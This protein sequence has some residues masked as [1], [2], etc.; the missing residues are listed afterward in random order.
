LP[1]P[2]TAKGTMLAPRRP[3]N[4]ENVGSHRGEI[5]IMY[6]EAGQ[7][8]TASMTRPGISNGHRGQRRIEHRRAAAGVAIE[9]QEVENDW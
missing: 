5:R 1:L 2:K 8:G 4:P 3:G 6:S 7:P 9:I